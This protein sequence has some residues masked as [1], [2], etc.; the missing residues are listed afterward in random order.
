MSYSDTLLRLL[1]PV[2]YNRTAAGIRSAAKIDGNCL[3][4]V[5]SSASRILGVINPRTS[6]NY[7]LRWEQVLGLSGIGLNAQQR[8][9]AVLAKLN[10]IGGLSIPYFKQLA[11]SIGYSIT[12]TEPQPFRA[13]VNRAGD[14]L[15][16]EDIMWAWWVNV[17]NANSQAAYFRAGI[18][19]AGD[20]LT[21]YGDAIIETMFRDLK[22]AFTNIRF[23]Y[24][25]K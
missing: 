7:I 15:A 6:G 12:I 23:T 5:Q 17:N 14:M 20:R 8:I 21:D 4:G 16:R 2:S 13:G 24:E 11:A 22:P 10:E 3:D 19:A 9:N 18:S 25:G 1:P